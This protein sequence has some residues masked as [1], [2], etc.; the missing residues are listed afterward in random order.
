MLLRSYE[1]FYVYHN[2]NFLVDVYEFSCFENAFCECGN[3]EPQ[4]L[5]YA[6]IEP[7]SRIIKGR[8]LI[9]QKAKLLI[10]ILCS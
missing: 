6:I 4:N 8:T 10:A 7:S 3:M 5:L 1:Y 2:A 9:V